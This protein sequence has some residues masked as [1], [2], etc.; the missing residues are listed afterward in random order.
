MTNLNDLAAQLKSYIIHSQENDDSIRNFNRNRY[1]NLTININASLGYP[2]VNVSIG[3]F[4]AVYNIEYCTKT[5][6][7]LE[8]DEIYVYKWL[9]DKNIQNVLKELYLSMTELVDLEEEQSGLKDE[10]GQGFRRDFEGAAGGSMIDDN[11]SSRN[12]KRNNFRNLMMPSPILPKQEDF[13]DEI[14]E[15]YIRRE[16]VT[17]TPEKV[18]PADYEVYNEETCLEIYKEEQMESLED[19]SRKHD[20]Y[21]FIQNRLVRKKEDDE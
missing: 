14:K 2:N 4:E 13:E 7:S 15:K 5:E 19:A 10:L 9:S 16:D 6:G 20:F 8:T 12:K 21:N 18:V 17:L 1:N 11:F 3:G